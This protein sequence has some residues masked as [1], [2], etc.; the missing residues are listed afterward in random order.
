MNLKPKERKRKKQLIREKNCVNIYKSEEKGA[1]IIGVRE[2]MKRI[3]KK[4]KTGI[5]IKPM[6]KRHSINNRNLTTFINEL[7]NINL[8]EKII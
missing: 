5:R 7:M 2:K 4:K 6:P 3:K 1:H 8:N